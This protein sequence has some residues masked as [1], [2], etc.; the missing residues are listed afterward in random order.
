M[1]ASTKSTKKVQFGQ[2]PARDDRSTS[3]FG[4]TPEDL[5]DDLAEA[6]EFPAQAQNEIEP[7]KDDYMELLKVVLVK[8][9]E[10]VKKFFLEQ[11]DETN[12]KLGSSMGAQAFSCK[13]TLRK[14]Q[15]L[16]DV[17]SMKLDDLEKVLC[18]P[19][20]DTV[21]ES[22][23]GTLTSSNPGGEP[24][25]DEAKRQLIF[26][27]NSLQGHDL[28]ANP[29]SLR[30][31]RSLSALVPYFKENVMY[32]I[33]ALTE[34]AGSHDGVDI[35]SLLKTIF[36]DEWDNFSERQEIHGLSQLTKH[37]I[38]DLCEWASNRGQTLC[39]LVHGL[40]H[41]RTALA[42]IA[43][44]EGIRDAEAERLVHDKFELIVAAQAYGELKASKKAAELQKAKAIDKL[45]KQF[46]DNLRVAYVDGDKTADR[47]Y[48]VLLAFDK[49]SGQSKELFRVMLPGY[50]ILGEGKP[51]NQNHSVIFTRGQCL[52]TLDMNQ[53]AYMGEAFKMRNLLEGFVGNVKLIGFREHIF[54]ETAGAVASFAA[55]NEFVFGTL[56]QRF[57]TWPLN[58]RFHYG[59]PDVWDK[60]WALTNGGVSKASKTLHVSEDV[61]GG[62][63]VMLRGGSISYVEYIHCGKGRDLGFDAVSAFEQK[64]STGN[65]MQML[66]RDLFRLSKVMDLAR[67]HSLFYSSHG[68]FFSM[69]VGMLAI[70]WI[71]V[72]LLVLHLCGVSSFEQYTFA[73]SGTSVS[74]CTIGEGCGDNEGTLITANLEDLKI[75]EVKEFPDNFQWGR[76]LQLDASPPLWPPPSPPSPPPPPP[77]S[78]HPPSSPS[79]P[80]MPPLVP[81]ELSFPTNFR[82]FCSINSRGQ[83][84]AT[85]SAGYNTSVINTTAFD[86]LCVDLGPQPPRKRKS[87]SVNVRRESPEVLDSISAAWQAATLNAVT[88]IQLSF[89]L[90]VPLV[91]ELWLEVGLFSALS[92]AFRICVLGC[93]YF[94]FTMQTKA[95]YF[96]S[97]FR[98]GKATYI[99]TG[100][101]YDLQLHSFEQLFVSYANSHI[102]LAAEIFVMLIVYTI[103]TAEYDKLIASTF[104]SWLSAFAL[105]FSPWIFTAH[106]WLVNDVVLSWVAWLNWMRGNPNSAKDSAIKSSW[107]EWHDGRMVPK[108]KSPFRKVLIE[109]LVSALPVL[110]MIYSACCGIVVKCPVDRLEEL[111]LDS[112]TMLLHK[113]TALVVC[114][115]VWCALSVSLQIL[116]KV[117]EVVT[118][119]E[120]KGD[121]PGSVVMWTSMWL[122]IVAHVTAFIVL[123]DSLVDHGLGYIDVLSGHREETC[124]LE[125]YGGR[126]VDEFPGGTGDAWN[127]MLIV[128]AV[129]LGWGWI[130][131]TVANL[132]FPTDAARKEGEVSGSF[133][134]GLGKM[135]GLKVYSDFYLKM[136]DHALAMCVFLVLFVFTVLPLKAYQGSLLY[137]AKFAH[138]LRAL[139][140]K[141]NFLYRLLGPAPT[142][143]PGTADDAAPTAQPNEN[144]RK[145]DPNDVVRSRKLGL[146]GAP[147]ARPRYNPSFSVYTEHNFSQKIPEALEEEEPDDWDESD[148]SGA[149]PDAAEAPNRDSSAMM[150]FAPVRQLSAQH[151]GPLRMAQML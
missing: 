76:R 25:N 114:F 57:M 101:D 29:P 133:F 73:T 19:A 31:M 83:V 77:T 113:F 65:S 32:S 146:L 98:F 68:F 102:Y 97:G 3:V 150:E 63:N 36:P 90:L 110:L 2:T 35:F 46:P 26:F 56:T 130:V 138:I 85:D 69:F 33:D 122:L 80:E 24:A 10:D 11:L 89:F 109:R 106:G 119:P 79:P 28:K 22:L 151:R 55:A 13:T 131:Q 121:M 91:M 116:L 147:G 132:D 27:C 137:N 88:T 78:P 81:D 66:S 52:Q 48:S 45:R 58:V 117:T 59:H 129:G 62:F 53:D 14:M 60:V 37:N 71:P 127:I 148:Q 135:L 136:L 95:Y 47:C 149:L 111:P 142:G 108:R 30:E 112:P 15:S 7:G 145:T 39:R 144:T 51:E 93:T 6:S 49:E 94:V 9:L 21:L 18:E 5:S 99:A 1:M 123:C 42:T 143:N 67:L 141:Q 96:A 92:T 40:M 100:R 86:K 103:F 43:N 105:M 118:G 70:Y 23:L 54:S 61:F 64:I 107:Q 125:A 41:H 115:C 44:L 8:V 72:C 84:F 139:V 38:D 74:K 4:R 104:F 120:D 87:H 16:I 82:Q 140:R 12:G 134:G 50:P 124:I 128:L 20:M 75:V 17:E 34:V 126:S